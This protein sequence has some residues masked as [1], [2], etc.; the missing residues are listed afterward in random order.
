MADDFDLIIE[1]QEYVTSLEAQVQDLKKKLS[2]TS[3]DLIN[4]DIHIGRLS[5]ERLKAV[6][7][8][9]ILRHDLE[10]IHENYIDR[11]LFTNKVDTLVRILHKMRKTSENPEERKLLQEFIEVLSKANEHQEKAK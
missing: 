9:T 4:K 2:D 1:L 3:R 5:S 6:K 7:D 10:R 11:R 8:A